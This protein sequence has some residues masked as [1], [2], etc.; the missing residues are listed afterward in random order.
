M[1]AACLFALGWKPAHTH[2]HT[3]TLTQHFISLGTGHLYDHGT[4]A[5]THMAKVQVAPQGGE[6]SGPLVNISTMGGR[7]RTTFS[8]ASVF[9]TKTIFPLVADLTLTQNVCRDIHR[10]TANQ[11][12]E[13]RV[14][15]SY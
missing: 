13:Y 5:G 2:T 1:P 6:L 9:K 8:N 4:C 10:E 11:L 12:R 3:H 15:L 7:P 14:S